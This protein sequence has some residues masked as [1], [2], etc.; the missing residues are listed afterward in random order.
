MYFEVFLCFSWGQGILLNIKTYMGV[1][2]YH[3]AFLNEKKNILAIFSSYDVSQ[4]WG[5]DIC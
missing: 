3:S 1:V 4:G 2:S 5:A